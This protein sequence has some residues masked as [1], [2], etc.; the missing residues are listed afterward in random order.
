MEKAKHYPQH[1]LLKTSRENIKGII[2]MLEKAQTKIDLEL[3]YFLPDNIGR[4]VLDILIYKAKQGVQIRLLVDSM[5]SFSLSQSLYIDAFHKVG[6]NIR[7]FNSFVPFSSSRKSIWYLRNHRRTIIVDEK[8]LYVGSL[9]I[10]EGTE[11]WI[12]T[13]IK[14][15]GSQAVEQASK[16]FQE[17][18]HKSLHKT[19]KIGSSQKAS[20][21]CYSYITQAPLQ[22]QRYIYHA[23]INSIRSA[24]EQIILVAPYIIPDNRLFRALRHAARRKV[25]VILVTTKDTDSFLAD[26]GRD[27]FISHM[28]MAGI[29]IYFHPKLVHS[30]IAIFDNESA[31]V[32][33]MNLDN[34]SLRYNYENALI[35]DSPDCIKEILEHV[36]KDIIAP[37][38]KLSRHEWDHRSLWRQFLE[39]LVFPI[40][41][42]L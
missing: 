38:K 30:K 9:C 22:G 42:L 33:T 28:L 6:I 16:A 7:F 29:T 3:F 40:R 18:W 34:V 26:L 37:S 13:G 15:S 31:H 39:L 23:L 5:G 19:F 1:T 17:T 4:D 11:D 21:D 25:K 27:T 2:D 35:T 14:I 20:T 24:K 36:E 12:E 32:G 41:K 10:G 8:T